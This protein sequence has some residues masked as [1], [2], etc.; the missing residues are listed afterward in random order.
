MMILPAA[1]PPSEHRA[2]VAVTLATIFVAVVFALIVTGLIAFDTGVAIFLA[3]MAWA[4][5]EML[6][7]Q[8]ELDAYHQQSMPGDAAWRGIEPVELHES[9]L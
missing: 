5:Y 2:N 7:Y 6:G 8:R 1:E 3:C 4:I 9:R